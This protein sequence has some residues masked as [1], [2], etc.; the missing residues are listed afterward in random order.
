MTTDA[1]EST[2]GTLSSR[3]LQGNQRYLQGELA[4][5]KRQLQRCL[6]V[7]AADA[8]TAA[9]PA[10]DVAEESSYSA[11]Q[12]QLLSSMNRP[13]ALLSLCQVFELS[14]FERDVVLL[15]A[16]IELDGSFR[17][18]CAQL[19]GNRAPTFHLAL[20]VLSQP[21][22]SALSPQGPLRCA[23]LIELAPG[24]S[25]THAPLQLSE[26]VLHHLTGVTTLDGRLLAFG[27]LLSLPRSPLPASLQAVADRCCQLLTQVDDKLDDG[28]SPTVALHGPA[29]EDHQAVAAQACEQVGLILFQLRASDLPSA[30]G[31]RTLLQQLIEREQQ[32]LGLAVLLRVEDHDPP[33]VVRS[34]LALVTALPGPV[35]CSSHAPLRASRRQLV[36]VAVPR[37]RAEERV[38]VLREILGADAAAA[39]NDPG[40][41]GA[42]LLTEV[43]HHFQLSRAGLMAACQVV[44]SSGAAPAS[45]LWDACRAQ[46]RPHLDELARRIEPRLSFD[47]LVLP[48]PQLRQL[49][50]LVAH[51]RKQVMV[52]SRWGMAHHSQRGLGVTALLVG[53]SGT[54][55]TL[56]AE[57]LA[58]ELQQDLYHI[59]L[60][61]IVSKYIG[62][63]E[64]NLRRVFDAAEE[65]GAVLLFDEADA[66]FGKRSEVKDSHDRY[67]NIEVSYLLQ[68]MEAYQG[69]TLLTSNLRSA[70]DSA[71]LRRIRFIVQ[72]P[73]PDAAQRVELWQRAFPAATPTQGLSI[74][75][76]ARLSVTGGQI[77]N[78]ALGAAFLAAASDQPVSMQHIL[79]AAK[80]EY[81]K[82][83]RPLC[84]PEIRGW[85]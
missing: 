55:K 44:Q 11:A 47:D 75:K 20:S 12:V 41:G 24:E 23:R 62:E 27:Q 6:R 70:L 43:A 73:F 16:G 21:H 34:G 42:G 30:L 45:A 15:C 36:S 37:L 54:G 81:E 60:S 10:S 18:L 33:E 74:E 71:F 83:E 7:A 29:A 46:A 53:Q 2:S 25:L 39:E 35:L 8:E 63:T 49:R 26:R 79:E 59:D 61:Q 58:H 17:S 64:K 56:A 5:I 77:R 85:V 48:E 57:A 13:P 76:L 1:T 40:L 19:G 31:E 84:E 78:I 4:R 14:A 28:E 32:L 67:A 68:R 38:E 82:I 52:Y 50:Q 3:W 66:L 65:A 80:S 9:V 51:Q 22:F 72:F 69:V